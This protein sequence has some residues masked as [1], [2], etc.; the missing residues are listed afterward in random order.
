LAGMTRSLEAM[1]IQVLPQQAWKT[2]VHQFQLLETIL[3]ETHNTTQVSEMSAVQIFIT[4]QVSEI[5]SIQISEAS[6]AQGTS[7]LMTRK[8]I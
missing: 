6:M 1:M 3:I 2:R 7:H 4:N 8:M 5:I